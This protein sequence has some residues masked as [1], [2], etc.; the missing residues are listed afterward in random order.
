MDNNG[1][2]TFHSYSDFI[3]NKTIQLSVHGYKYKHEDFTQTSHGNVAE[4]SKYGTSIN[5]GS[6]D[7]QLFMIQLYLVS[8]SINF[9]KIRVSLKVSCNIP[10][11]SDPSAFFSTFDEQS[12]MK[13]SSNKLLYCI[14]SFNSIVDFRMQLKTNSSSETVNL[15]SKDLLLKI[16]KI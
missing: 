12:I 8:K 11:L 7:H 14:G 15:Y 9:S 6:Y 3:L 5:I 2:I 1:K 10:R 4:Q 13:D 16:I